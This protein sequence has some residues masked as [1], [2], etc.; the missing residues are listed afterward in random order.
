MVTS[1]EPISS[2][3]AQLRPI[4]NDRAAEHVFTVP[5]GRLKHG[6]S[7]ARKVRSLT[8]AQHGTSMVHFLEAVVKTRSKDEVALRQRIHGVEE[9][10]SE[11]RCTGDNRP[12]D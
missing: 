11:A 12:R 9:R 4:A 5:A 6:S 1:S 2:M 7:V 10:I 8:S 3:L